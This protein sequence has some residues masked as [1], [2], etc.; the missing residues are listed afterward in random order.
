MD[1]ELDALSGSG[2]EAAVPL[3]PLPVPLAEAP[4]LA[5][6]PLPAPLAEAPPWAEVPVPAPV[7]QPA[8]ILA[9]PMAGDLDA[10]PDNSEEEAPQQLTLRVATLKQSYVANVSGQALKR[11]AS[12]LRLAAADKQKLRRGIDK[13]IL[14]RSQSSADFDALAACWDS[15]QLRHGDTT[16]CQRVVNQG[17]GIHPNAWTLPGTLR[18][19]FQ[20]IGATSTH[21]GRATTHNLSA[22]GVVSL[23]AAAA[24]DE[25]IKQFVASI[26]CGLLTP[27]WL[28]LLSSFDLT[29]VSLCFGQLHDLIAPLVGCSSNV[30]ARGVLQSM[31][32]ISSVHWDEPQEE[33]GVVPRDEK[34]LCPPVV[35]ENG[36]G[37]NLVAA[38]RKTG[39]P[40][41][42]ESLETIS[43]VVPC[44]ALVLGA[45]LAGSN[46]RGFRYI[47]SRFRAHS[48]EM[49]RSGVHHFL[50]LLYAA[51][52][53]HILHGICVSTFSGKHVMPRLHG[54]AFVCGL[55][56]HYNTLVVTLVRKSLTS[57]AT[58]HH[59][60][61][62]IHA[63]H[64]WQI[65][66][67]SVILS[68]A[69]AKAGLP[70]AKIC[71]AT[72]P[73]C[74]CSL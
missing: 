32:Q 57:S 52:V 66:P 41:S 12:T 35:L 21:H 53:A 36:T 18:V 71:C 60:W 31:G 9:A 6:V 67:Y 39:G 7:P 11:A 74:C 56:G 59:L 23:C 29:P 73:P 3:P 45:D 13:E 16:A 70:T 5:V 43:R 38:L 68:P 48:E 54:V 50:L 15:T 30:E 20:G 22:M 14:S 8:P 69:A 34:R 10:L 46:Q 65:S 55:T 25:H 37:S 63:T 40:L 64:L 58:V 47:A 4:P 51:C 42:F 62:S 49:H 72:G 17:R 2:D 44:I 33:G 24:R 27:P 28:L 19:A 1:D 61:F 26:Q